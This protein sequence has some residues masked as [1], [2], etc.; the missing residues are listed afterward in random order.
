MLVQYNN[1]IYDIRII[2]LKEQG[3]YST[4][5][6]YMD[7]QNNKLNVLFVP[8][9]KDPNGEVALEMHKNTKYDDV[10]AK[11]A[12]K[13]GADADKIQFFVPNTTTTDEPRH[14]YARDPNDTLESM[15]Y[16]QRLGR[17]FV[18][19]K[20]FYEVLDVSLSEL[21]SK[22][23]IKVTTCIP[24]L[25]DGET[26][27]LWISKQARITDLLKELQI[28]SNPSVRVFEAI[29]NRFHREFMSTDALAQV[30]DSHAAQLYIEVGDQCIAHLLGPDT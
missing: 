6:E 8:R 21:E 26:S 2:A 13:I 15:L 22:R 18:N 16:T 25:K 14:P 1:S 9:D 23:L 20:L 24:T 30:S 17:P 28:G 27:K 5:P 29:N 4:V 11:L 12:E 7:Y 3:L 10:S 19:G